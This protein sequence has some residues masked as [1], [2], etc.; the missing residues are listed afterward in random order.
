MDTTLKITP[1]ATG[2]KWVRGKNIRST[3]SAIK[4]IIRSANKDLV[5]TVFSLTDDEI[6][7]AIIETLDRGVCTTIYISCGELEKKS[8]E[9][10]AVNRL[11]K[12]KEEYDYLNIIP[13][14]D[15]VLHAKIVIADRELLYCGSANLSYNGMMNNYELGLMV[16]SYETADKFRDLLLLLEKK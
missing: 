2:K 5:L 15:A 12:Q 1:V 6:V 8:D 13:V 11:I 10:T 4:E 3:P 7:D 16:K 14:D 9:F